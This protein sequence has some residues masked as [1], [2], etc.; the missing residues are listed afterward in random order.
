VLLGPIAPAT[1]QVTPTFQ[2]RSL[3]A[4]LDSPG[5]PYGFAFVDSDGDGREDLYLPSSGNGTD[6]NGADRFYVNL[7]GL[8][9][10]DVASTVGLANLDDA[11]A[12]L[13]GDLDNDGDL[14]TL[15]VY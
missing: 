11:R 6:P 14:D 10:A 9:F 4:G 2:E 7:D 1:A 13:L 12:G 15:L 5:G 8:H 3:D